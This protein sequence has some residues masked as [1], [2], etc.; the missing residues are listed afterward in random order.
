MKLSEQLNFKLTPLYVL[1]LH[2]S[3]WS[4]CAG[5]KQ[6]WHMKTWEWTCRHVFNFRACW[7]DLCRSMFLMFVDSICISKHL[8][9]NVTQEVTLSLTYFS[10]QQMNR[11]Y[12]FL[13]AYILK[14]HWR[15]GVCAAACVSDTCVSVKESVCHTEVWEECHQPRLLSLPVIDKNPDEGVSR[16]WIL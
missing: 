3:S 11:I 2:H 9:P 12:S 14:W 13:K 5:D 16:R 1:C 7:A 6:A 8:C 15:F 4:G 10:L